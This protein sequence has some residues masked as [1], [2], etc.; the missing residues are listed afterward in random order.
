ML[1]FRAILSNNTYFIGQDLYNVSSSSLLRVYQYENTIWFNFIGKFFIATWFE[2]W[3]SIKFNEGWPMLKKTDHESH[4]KPIGNYQIIHIN[5]I[6]SSYVRWIKIRF[7][8]NIFWCIYI[9]KITN[10]LSKYDLNLSHD[11]TVS[12]I[13][14]WFYAW[15]NDYTCKLYAN[16]WDQ[17]V[18]YTWL[19]ISSKI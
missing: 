17:M 10:I 8:P 12:H 7:R 3:L 2:T 15:L 6:L 14:L 5:V 19:S 16:L 9:Y 11:K 4:L 18:N 13:F 1:T